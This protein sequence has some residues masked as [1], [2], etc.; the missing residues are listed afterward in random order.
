PIE[1][2]AQ[3]SHADLLTHDE[4]STNHAIEL[5]SLALTEATC[6]VTLSTSSAIAVARTLILHCLAGELSSRP[7]TIVCHE[8]RAARLTSTV[9]IALTDGSDTSAHGI[10]A[11][12]DHALSAVRVGQASAVTVRSH[13][14]E[15]C[16]GT[17]GERLLAIRI[18]HAAPLLSA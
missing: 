8:T 16:R 17:V 3:G 10:S 1:A 6:A 18:A 5:L 14:I 13:Q 4:G 15:A 7:T 9:L 12:T 2:L 11:F